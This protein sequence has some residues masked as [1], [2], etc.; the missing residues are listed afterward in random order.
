LLEFDVALAYRK[1]S[2]NLVADALSRAAPGQYE[3]GGNV[4]QI[5]TEAAGANEV[6][7][8]VQ[9]E[10]GVAAAP[11]QRR[12]HGRAAKAHLEAA[13]IRTQ[14]RAVGDKA[15]DLLL[16]DWPW[17]H[18]S[19]PNER[20][21]RRMTASEWPEVAA[22]LGRVAADDAIIAM[23]TPLCML[24]Q[25]HSAF[26]TDKHMPAW[27]YHTSLVW[28]RQ[29]ATASRNWPRTEYEVVALFSRGNYAR[30]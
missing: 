18:D 26:F 16:V 9:R 15:Y 10:M 4:R 7:V 24:Q 30:V 13:D 20:D 8:L 28:D 5:K 22:Q 25:L 21:Y 23:C 2:D 17:R 1:G 14:L 27:R 19:D 29:R 12:L 6:A 3:K 11:K